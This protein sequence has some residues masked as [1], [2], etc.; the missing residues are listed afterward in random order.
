M[1]AIQRHIL[2]PALRSTRVTALAA[3]I[4]LLSF[5][6]CRSK[7][8]A[9]TAPAAGPIEVAV[10]TLAPE[11]VT[12]TRELPGR[13][14]AFLVAEVRPQVSGIVQ[15]RLFTEGN[16][17]KEGEPLYQLEDATYQANYQSAQASLARA[18]ATLELARLNAQRSGQLAKADAV[19][20]Q[21]NENAVAEL[22]QAEAEIAV[23][24]AA[25][26]A[27]GVVLGYSKITSPIG[28]RIGKSSVTQGAL[29]TA[30]QQTP[31]ATVQQLDPIYVDLTQSSREWLQLRQDLASGS[32][33]RPDEMPVT[34]I[35]EDGSEYTHPGKLAFTEVTVDPSTGSFGL[36][37]IV[38]NPDQILLPGMYVRAVVG[39]GVRENAILVPQQ[40]IT[41]D[42]RG[43]ATAMTVGQDGKAEL[44]Q[45]R[46]SRTI[47][48][49]WLV[50]SGLAAGDKVVVAGVQKIRPGSPL[51][52]VNAARA[53]V[54]AVT[55]APAAQL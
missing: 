40:G 9:T 51:K 39:L 8:A 24:E 16:L 17:V 21:E 4:G 27:S 50:E 26:T 1:N 25:V 6:G 35:L 5:A 15:R 37:V 19:S 32:L 22:R 33:Q 34:I 20:R 49:K 18:R 3:L 44:R 23:A 42:P 12:L 14:N 29:V 2:R 10:T 52:P 55:P 30:N 48:S 41:R 53:P 45:V 31:L 7:E 54:G 11:T 43:N 46:V 13:T 47:G 28:G 36:R 38:P